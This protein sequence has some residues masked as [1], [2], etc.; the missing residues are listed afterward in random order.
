MHVI[1]I[2]IISI[3]GFVVACLLPLGS[4]GETL[5]LQPLSTYQL[6]CGLLVAADMDHVYVNA[7]LNIVMPQISTF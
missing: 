1:Y 2:E 3:Y 4:L 5:S 7:N 6:F